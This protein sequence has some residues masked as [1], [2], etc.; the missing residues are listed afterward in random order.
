M[1]RDYF[2]RSVRQTLYKGGVPQSAVKSLDLFLDVTDGK[3]FPEAH[4]AY[5]LATAYHEVGPA[6]VPRRES[7]NYSVQGLLDTFGRH[8]I[9]DAEAKRLGRQPGEKSVPVARQRQI[10]NIV[11]GGEWGR[12][13]LGNTQPSDGWD[14]RGGGYPQAT[15]R[16]NFARLGMLTGVPLVM[17][18]ERITEPAVAVVATVEAMTVGLYTGKALSDYRLPEQ[19]AAARAVINADG[20]VNG[21]KIAGYARHFLTALKAGKYEPNKIVKGGSAAVPKPEPVKVEP[22]TAQGPAPGKTDAAVTTGVLIGVVG[23]AAAGW[24]W[25]SSLPCEYLNLFCGN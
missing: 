17:S 6:L 15:G 3:G 11:Y 14:F 18:P 23:A 9:M 24:H 10:A 20:K 21:E 25:L 2:F 19:F 13:N 8:R 16:A 22:P 7:L 5:M 1:D 12:K 4:V